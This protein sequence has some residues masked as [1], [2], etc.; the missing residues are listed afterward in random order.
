MAIPATGWTPSH[1]AVSPVS[2]ARLTAALSTTT[3]LDML[4]LVVLWLLPL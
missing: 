2:Q 1:S 3:G 4:L